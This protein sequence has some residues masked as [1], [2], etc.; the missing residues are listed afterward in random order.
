MRS[1]LSRIEQM[2][3]HAEDANDLPEML[4]SLRN[5][6]AEV[7]EKRNAAQ[8]YDVILQRVSEL[9][10]DGMAKDDEIGQLKADLAMAL[11]ALQDVASSAGSTREAILG[12]PLDEPTDL[13]RMTKDIL[14]L[15][16]R[17]ARADHHDHH[18]RRGLPLGAC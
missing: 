13:Q 18:A 3:S 17:E 9:Q 4:S 14:R 2:L 7:L 15:N 12:E 8:L 5:I 10:R 1:F 6:R 11:D 16:D